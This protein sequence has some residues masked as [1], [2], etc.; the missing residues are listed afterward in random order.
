MQET[1]SQ[2]A[3]RGSHEIRLTYMR[4][5]SGP[6]G[7]SEHT[8]LAEMNDDSSPESSKPLRIPEDSQ[9]RP[10]PDDWT[11]ATDPTTKKRVQNRVAQ[12]TYRSRMKKRLQEL[13]QQVY[14]HERNEESH[15]AQ[16][17]TQVPHSATPVSGCRFPD[18]QTGLSLP[19]THQFPQNLAPSAAAFEANERRQSMISEQ[20]MYSTSHLFASTGHLPLPEDMLDSPFNPTGIQQQHTPPFL[21]LSDLTVPS[22]LHSLGL[23]DQL[24]FDNFNVHD[25]T[26]SVATD[27]IQLTSNI[28]MQA[29][30]TRPTIPESSGSLGS[31]DS[32]KQQTSTSTETTTSASSLS[33][34]DDDERATQV[35]DADA[36]MEDRIGY[37]ISC[38]KQVGFDSLDSL[39]SAYYTRPFA[40]V[41]SLSAEQ[42]ISRHRRLPQVLAQLRQQITTWTQWER[43]GFEDEILR[44]AEDICAAECGRFVGGDESPEQLS[45]PAPTAS[46]QAATRRM[47][48]DEVSCVLLDNVI[49]YSA[50]KIFPVI[51]TTLMGVS[52]VLNVQ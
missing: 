37:V 43:T 38:A 26:A 7:F 49:R 41:S 29:P 48:Q 22:M 18:P 34:E 31:T 4:G 44:T 46:S 8:T 33:P 16:S 47:I 1:I 5:F 14:E 45:A 32:S 21:P 24:A 40:E 12:R 27:P 13:E 25:M 42:R 10:D 28:W 39:V 52:Y 9:F 23:G 51:I 50:R 2:C 11:T 3:L 15:Q 19:S 36:S 20:Q 35:P 30:S 17:L 6:S